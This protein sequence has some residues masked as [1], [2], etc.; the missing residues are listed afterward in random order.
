MH[1]PDMSEDCVNLSIEERSAYAKRKAGLYLFDSHHPGLET[2]EAVCRSGKHGSQFFE[3][4]HAALKGD[5]FLVHMWATI[6]VGRVAAGH[7]RQD[8]SWNESTASSS[9]RFRRNSSSQ[10]DSGIRVGSGWDTSSRATP[11]LEEGFGDNTQ[12]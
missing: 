7:A 3:I 12:S 1:S 2:L 8:D 10:N 5:R 11:D 9:L 4:G 6:L